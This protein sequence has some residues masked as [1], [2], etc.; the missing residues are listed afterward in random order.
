M[1]NILYADAMN[2]EIKEPVYVKQH[3]F[4]DDTGIYM[5]VEEYAPEGIGMYRLVLSKEMFV[6]AYNKWIDGG[7]ENE[8]D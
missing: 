8:K 7:S 5:P 2:A 3:P 6:E 4:V 1:N